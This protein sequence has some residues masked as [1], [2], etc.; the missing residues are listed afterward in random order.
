MRLFNA[1][2]NYCDGLSLSG[3][4]EGPKVVGIDVSN[5]GAEPGILLVNIIG[6]AVNFAAIAVGN[7]GKRLYLINQ[8]IFAFKRE[9]I[10]E[11]YI[12]I[13]YAYAALSQAVDLVNDLVLLCK[14]L[15]P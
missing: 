1:G 3:I 10:E 13:F 8:T 9:T 2:I 6:K 14:K 4:A 15:A 5:A 12:V 7:T 11:H